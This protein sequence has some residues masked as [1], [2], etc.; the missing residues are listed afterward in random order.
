MAYTAKLNRQNITFIVN[1]GESILDAA[2]RQGH[3]LPYGCRNGEC[4][5]CIAEI[6]NGTFFYNTE[7]SVYLEQG[8]LNEKK[9]FLCQARASSDIEIDANLLETE[10]EITIKQLPCRVKSTEKLNDSVMRIILELPKTEKLEFL[11]GQYVD[12]ILPNNKKRSFSLANPPHENQALEFHVRYYDGGVFSEYAFNELKNNA[13]LKIEGPL[14][15][16]TL[17]NSERPIIMIAGGTGFAPIKSIV[18]HTLKINDPRS[19]HFYWGA[20]LESDLYLHKI[21]NQWAEKYPHITYTPVLS[22]ID[23]LKNWSGRTGY[24]HGTV[25]EDYSDL[26]DHDVYACGPPPMIDAIVKTFPEYHLPKDSL[27]SDSFEFAKE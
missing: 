27:F 10:N 26:S 1:E 5:S 3:N 21:A 17:Q 12:F 7:N 19:I 20:R 24:V 8:S 2:I 15:Q 6:T 16:F 11:P 13:L 4:G 23:N 9:V 22:E 14:G 18:E 25:L